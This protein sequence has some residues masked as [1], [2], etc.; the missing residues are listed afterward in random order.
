MDTTRVCLFLVATLAG[1]A[2]LAG[3][4]RF[5]QTSNNGRKRVITYV[6][7]TD[8]NQFTG[9]FATLTERREI[10]NGVIDS[11]KITFDTR[12]EFDEPGRLTPFTGEI[13]GDELKI[14]PARPP[15]NGRPPQVTTLKRISTAIKYTPPPE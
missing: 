5:E 10:L 7:R 3:T 6:F 2:D 9:D 13:N 12:F 14:T 8:G 1:A 11:N 4:W 15:Q